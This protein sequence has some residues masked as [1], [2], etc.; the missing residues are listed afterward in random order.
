M[1]FAGVQVG[2]DILSTSGST[3]FK[4]AAAAVMMVDECFLLER[5]QLVSHYHATFTHYSQDLLGSLQ[6][7]R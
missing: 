5:I 7:A 6:T 3:S 1:S 4:L 2:T